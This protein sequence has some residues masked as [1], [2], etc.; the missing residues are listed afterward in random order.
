MVILMNQDFESYSNNKVN[1]IVNLGQY[2]FG[3]NES[4]EEKTFYQISSKGDTLIF[5]EISDDNSYDFNKI[6]KPSLEMILNLGK[7]S[8]KFN[9]NMIYLDLG[10]GIPL[11][12]GSIP[13]CSE[14]KQFFNEP[15]YQRF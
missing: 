15:L 12:S 3:V 2:Y 9:S 11:V 5:S 7:D 4:G 1:K 10:E 6:T 8:K 13:Y 14:M